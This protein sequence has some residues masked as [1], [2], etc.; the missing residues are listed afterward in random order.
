[1]T[2]KHRAGKEVATSKAAEA[3]SAIERPIAGKALPSRD[4]NLYLSQF[5]LLCR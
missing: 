2:P 1:M 3:P 5:W 4:F